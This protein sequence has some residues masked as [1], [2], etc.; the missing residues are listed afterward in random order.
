MRHELSNELPLDEP[1]SV[2]LRRTPAHATGLPSHA[3]EAAHSASESSGRQQAAVA[4]PRLLWKR[5][6]R[7][8]RFAPATE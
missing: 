1:L 3:R 4:L 8:F 5:K 7:H 2:S 6:W